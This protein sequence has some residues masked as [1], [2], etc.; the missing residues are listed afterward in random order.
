FLFQAI[1]IAGLALLVGAVMRWLW[2]VD[3][4]QRDAWLTDKG[5][6]MKT[7]TRVF[8]IPYLA[9]VGVK[10][11]QDWA[12]SRMGIGKITLTYREGEMYQKVTLIGVEH[13]GD[14]AQELQSRIQP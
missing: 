14:V 11:T 10:A 7:P 4:L 1:V 9:M 6:W 8:F 13:D 2:R 5:L 3:V 12:S